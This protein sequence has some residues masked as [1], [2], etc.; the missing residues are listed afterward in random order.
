MPFRFLFL[1]LIQSIWLLL[2]LTCPVSA[3][4]VARNPYCP[5]EPT[6]AA[7]PEFRADYAGET[8]YFCCSECVEIF[9]AD[10]SNYVAG[11]ESSRSQ[12]RSGILAWFDGIWNAAMLMPGLSLGGLTVLSLLSVRLL[13]PKLRPLLGAKCFAAIIGLSLAG[14]AVSAHRLRTQAEREYEEAKL[15]HQVHFS[16]FH[17][18]GDPP[19]PA[20]P[21]LPPRLQATFYRGNDERSRQLFNGGFYRTCDFVLDLCDS[22]GESIGYGSHLDI[23]DSFMRIRVTRAPGTPDFF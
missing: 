23:D 22:A 11:D 10:P 5:I 19:I 20:K 13:S 6:E 9:E 8:Y 15:I 4:T 21:Q 18:Y 16:T 7:L 2:W 12:N 14:E 3:E 1:S 17:E